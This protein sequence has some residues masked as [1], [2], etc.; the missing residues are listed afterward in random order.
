M[1][2]IRFFVSATY[3]VNFQIILIFYMSLCS[4]C[5]P[6]IGHLRRLHAKTQVLFLVA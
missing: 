5:L 1:H 4:V 3:S 2:L 6:S